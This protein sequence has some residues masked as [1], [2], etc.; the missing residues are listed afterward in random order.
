MKALLAL[1]LLLAMT[2]YCHLN[3]TSEQTCE[4][5]SNISATATVLPFRVGQWLPSDQAAVDK[6]LKK[7]IEEVYGTDQID[8]INAAHEAAG[9]EMLH[10]AIQD[11][12]TLIETDSKIYMFFHQM[13]EQVPY[14]QQSKSQVR[15]YKMMLRLLNHIMTKAPEFD[16]T[17]PIGLPIEV[18]L[19]RSEWTVGGYAAFLNEKVNAHFKRILNAWSMYLKSEESRYALTTS[20]TGWLGADAM[21][22]MPQFKE[23]YQCDPTK[24]YWGFKSWDDFFTREFRNGVRPIASPDNDSVICNACESSPYRIEHHVKRQSQFWIKS[25]NYSILFMLANNPFAEQFVGGT[26]YQAFLNILMYHR[27]HSPVNGKIVKSYI[28]S[29]K[30]FS[31]PDG[32]AEYQGYATEISTRALI[33]I[34]ADNPDIGLM[35][36]IAVGLAEVSS[37]EITVYDGQRVKKGQELGMFHYGG[38]TYCLIFHSGVKVDFDLRGQTPSLTSEPIHINARL[39]TVRHS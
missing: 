23:L 11:L 18:I 32:F 20:K 15:N 6:W 22:K 38:S 31:G 8:E 33:F 2:C 19:V 12:K 21:S 3:K 39:G 5:S 13:F 26:V 16:Q 7:L 34:E 36:F 24:P 4:K 28:V 10:P 30:Y 9:I 1:L 17:G 25:Q 29:G 27:W 37:C 35:C 14:N